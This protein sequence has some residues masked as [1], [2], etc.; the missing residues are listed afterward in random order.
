VA[1]MFSLKAGSLPSKGRAGD[2]YFTTDS[3]QIYIAVAD[4]ALL[5]LADLL[6]GAVPHVRVVGP[7]GEKGL[8][9][10]K[11]TKGDKGER[12]EKGTKGDKGDTGPRGKDGYGRDGDTGPQGKPG[13][14]GPA[15]APGRDGGRLDATVLAEIKLELKA[16]RG[17]VKQSDDYLEY[18]KEKVAKG[19]KSPPTTKV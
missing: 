12:G 10:E 8:Q 14:A 17:A 16:L 19:R 9:G 15:G 6:S 3:K 18:L 2:C 4:G 11:G 5:N 7:P 13:E 1:K